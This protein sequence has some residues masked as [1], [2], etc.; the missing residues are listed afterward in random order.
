M[1][2]R[3]IFVE[4]SDGGVIAGDNFDVYDENDWLATFRNRED[5]EEYAESK[6]LEP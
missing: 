3:E 2:E 6:R 5:A 4:R 1:S